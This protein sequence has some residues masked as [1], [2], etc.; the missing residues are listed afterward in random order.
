MVKLFVEGKERSPRYYWI[1]DDRCKTKYYKNM[2]A[3]AWRA[4]VRRRQDNGSLPAD[5]Q[6]GTYA[7]FKLQLGGH[8]YWRPRQCFGF[9]AKISGIVSPSTFDVEIRGPFG[10]L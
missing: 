6:E 7:Q 10:P 5:L 9:D 8:L 1:V 3:T 2:I 4:E